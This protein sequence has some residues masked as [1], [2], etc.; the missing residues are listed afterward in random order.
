MRDKYWH[1]MAS[2]IQRAW[3][4]YLRYRNECARRIQRFWMGKK[5][6]IVYAQMR[7]Y[8]HQVLGGRKERRRFSLLSMRKFVGDYLGAGDNTPQG[9][10]LRSAAG[11]GM[12][13][14]VTFSS[15][16][17]LL[18]SKLGRSSKPSPRFFLMTEKAAYFL[19]TQAVQGRTTTTLERK[20]NIVAI[21]SVGL[22]NLRDDWIVFNVSSATEPDPVFHCYFKTELVATL[23]RSTNGSVQVRIGP[24]IEYTKKKDK[25]ATIAFRKDESIRKDD[26]YKSHTV[27]VP[28]GD[29]PTSQSMPP[30]KRKPGISKPIAGGK[31]LRPGGPS[32][33]PAS[34]PAARPKPQA[35]A[36]PKTNGAAAA[37]SALTAPP[38]PKAPTQSNGS[39]TR[40][41]PPPPSRAGPPPPP[42]PP[43]A[44]E[45][46]DRYKAL[47]AFDTDQAGELA[48]KKDDI[49]EVVEKGETGWW[50]VK[51]GKR[52][53]WAPS[54]YIE[55]MPK[56]PKPKPAAPP[57]APSRRAP[58]AAP[59]APAAPKAPAAPSAPVKADSSAAPISVMPG[60]GNSGG[61]QAVLAAKRAAAASAEGSPENSRPSSR[62]GES[63]CALWLCHR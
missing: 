33:T 45:E 38:A 6:A 28:S 63:G 16:V 10:M 31:L 57:P 52:E 29:P 7:D 55:L 8:G 39:A 51:R 34:R 18:V 56:A 25:T 47:Y 59:A 48:L 37:T 13:E 3:R 20:I 22:S 32:K 4:N 50:L 15:R 11:I 9:E 21:R 2:R 27:S 61:L 12:G 62:T 41:V 42:P 19:I 5:E 26:V 43:P 30:A 40:S 49:V 46:P 53:G 60:T 14:S 24:T 54:N 1:N 58:A 17:E 44:A 23:Q 35:Q 36:L